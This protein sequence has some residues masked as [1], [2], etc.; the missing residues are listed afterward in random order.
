MIQHSFCD[1]SVDSLCIAAHFDDVEFMAYGP[2]AQ[3]LQT[4]RGFGAVVVTDGAGSARA[5]KYASVTDEQMV[6]LRVQEQIEAA[7]IGKYSLLAMLMQPSSVVKQGGE[8]LLQQIKQLIIKHKPTTVYTHNLFDKHP[9]HIAVCKAVIQ[10]LRQLDKK[11]LPKRLI[12]CEV[13]R[14]LDWMDD[15]QKVAMDTSYKPDFAQELMGVFESQI[16]GGK[17]YDK[18]VQGRWQANAT[19][20]ESHK[21]DTATRLSFGV[22]MTP[23]LQDT[24]MTV[25]AFASKQIDSLRDRVL[26]LL[27]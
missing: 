13:W 17:R 19:F 14:G 21:V 24:T 1:K 22:D 3:A 27:G 10:A 18:A 20:F 5:G 8:P 16:E 11:D 15:S 6:M 2:I 9:T 4:E 7:K 12:G 23:L 26:A 25:Q